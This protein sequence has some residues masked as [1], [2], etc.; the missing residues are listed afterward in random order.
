MTFIDFENQAVLLVH[1]VDFFTTTMDGPEVDGRVVPAWDVDAAVLLATPMKEHVHGFRFS[2]WDGETLTSFGPAYFFG[3]YI[4]TPSQ[5]A[6]ATLRREAVL[7]EMVAI[8]QQDRIFFPSGQVET[9]RSGDVQLP[10][11]V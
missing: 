7:K 4:K 1:K 5:I 6:T 3:G 10:E 2:T 9:F 8:D 11:L